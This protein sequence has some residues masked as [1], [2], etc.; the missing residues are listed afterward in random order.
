M[1]LTGS[2]DGTARLWVTA[3]GKPLSD[4]LDH[5]KAV[6]AVA[7]SHDSKIALTGSE[8]GTARF[9]HVRTGKPVGPALQH[10][11]KV[12]SVAFSPDGK[13]AVTGIENN[14]AR[15]WETPLAL[16]GE[17]EG[18]VSWAEV[19]S[20]MELDAAGAVRFLTVEEWQ[21]RRRMVTVP[22]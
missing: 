18:I 11:S 12:L 8:D 16:S 9:W 5:P 6:I 1:V 2:S 22:D 10:G 14:S 15:V 3:T 21:E 20:G 7:F 4:I 17:V 19:I 13:N